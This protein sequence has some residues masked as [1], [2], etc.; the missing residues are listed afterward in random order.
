MASVAISQLNQLPK[1][2]IAAD[3]ELPIVDVSA[4]ETK[5]VEVSDLVEKGVDLI[6][7]SSID[8]AKV[9]QAST[10]KFGTSALADSAVTYAKIQNASA[11]VLLGRSTAGAGVVE[12]IACTAAGRALLD[13][14]DTATQRATLGLGTLAI[15]NASGVTIT[16]GSIT[17][18]AVVSATDGTFTNVT[19]SGGSITGITD[20]AIADGGTGASTASG[21]RTNLGVAIGSDV[22]AYDA[23]LQSISGLTTSADQTLY[24]TASDTYAV[25]GLTSFGR[26]LIDDADAATA[27]TTLGLGTISTLS[28]IGTA[29][30]SNSAITTAL[31]NDDAVTAAK[32]ADN[33]A[34]VVA[35]NAPSTAGAFI[36]Q[37]HINNNTGFTYTWDGTS[38]IRTSAI[39]TLTFSDTTPLTFAVTYPDAYSATITTTLDTQAANTVLAGPTT[40]AN[41]APTFRALTAADMPIATS[42]DLGAV[43]PGT[44]LSVTAGGV[45]NH[46]NTTTAGT[47]TKVT[48][49]AQG[50]ISSGTTLVAGDVPSLDASKITT[51]TFAAGLFG[52]N[53]I[54]GVKLADSSTVQFGGAGSTSGVV[55][56]PNAEF[57]GQQF[58]DELNGDLYLWSGSAWLPITITSGELVYAGAYNASNNQVASVTSAGS[59]AGLTVGA[60]L[61]AAS[62]TNNRYYVV[63]S[64]SGTGTGNAPA[65][66]LAPPDMI[67][68]NGATWDLI[69]VSN[70]IAGQT[71]SNISFTPYGGIIATNVQTALQEL[72][73]D[74]LAKAGGTM[75]GELLIGHTGSFKFEGSTDNAYET[76]IVVVD[77][78]ADRTITVPN[79]SGTLVT[80][81]D[82]GT[83][84]S[85]MIADGTIVDADINASA[86]ISGS[87]I[88]AATTSV[89]GVVQLTDS[90][91]STSTSTAATPN[92]VKSAY[93]L[94]NAALPKSGGTMTGAITFAA[95]QTISGY[96]AIDTAQTWTK[97]QRGEITALTDGATITPDF[98]DSNNFSVTL[99]GNRTLAN[100]SNL[101][102]GQS[103]CIWI[104][105]DGTGSRTL[106]YGSY[107]DFTSGT[108]P[109]L[110]TTA[111]AV[112]CLVYA[113]Q[114]STKITA[115]LITNLS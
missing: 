65:V 29:N 93:D 79:V 38:W 41:A 36:G 95:G 49:D 16:G 69:D 63:V 97:G 90:T 80:T 4:N 50:H 10:T 64:Q 22:Q 34:T 71:A 17:G 42:V 11:N 109:T 39:S 73:D 3:D 115:T 32:L 102:A 18:A 35:G 81:G 8:I 13:D 100:P 70:A 21:A 30:V 47:Y 114:S 101:T 72:D 26:S 87:K 77:P 108:A 107:W 57:K 14:P 85:T 110:T 43:I 1:A 88:V 82:T 76:E 105:Q 68:S 104:T 60:G 89:V 99:G 84:T 40:G 56:F 83:V 6:A 5:K 113:V 91:S 31:I 59:A 96:G 61:P 48:V 78:T 7:N 12:E 15:Q 54:T 66:A 24:T 67:L 111:N 74:K 52:T 106:S 51:G 55:T 2:G 28:T 112:D 75:T 103:G 44:G 37:R 45:L 98:A 9:N 25:T 86:A 92:A 20:L 62:S 27:R 58:W 46:T 94:A 23:A 33:S 19:I 53:S